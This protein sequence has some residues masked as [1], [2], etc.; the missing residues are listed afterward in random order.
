MLYVD[1]NGCAVSSLTTW[2][3]ERGNQPYREGS[4]YAQELSA[5]SGYEMATGYGLTTHFYNL[6]NHLVPEAGRFH[7]DDHGLCSDAAHRKATSDDTSYQ[8]GELWAV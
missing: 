4:T 8:C 2:E 5:R 3:D 7:D 1:A 6:Q